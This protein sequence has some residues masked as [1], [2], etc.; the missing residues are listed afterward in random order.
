MKDY[1]WTLQHREVN[2]ANKIDPYKVTQGFYWYNDTEFENTTYAYSDKIKVSPNQVYQGSNGVNANVFRYVTF[3]DYNGVHLSDLDGWRDNF[4]VPSGAY[5]CVVTFYSLEQGYEDKNIGMTLGLAS[6]FEPYY[7]S[8]EVEAIYKQLSRGYKLES[9]KQF[10]REKMDGGVKLIRE[11]FDYINALPFD[12]EF[13]IL[14]EDLTGIQRDYRGLF[15]KTD[16]KWDDDDRIVELK[17]EPDDEYVNVLAGLDKT[18]NLINLAPE[19]QEITLRRRPLIQVYIPGDTVVTNILGGTHWE[20]EIQTDPIFDH[21]ALINTYKFANPKNIRIVP[22]SYAAQLSTD[23]TGEYDDNRLNANGLYRLEEVNNGVYWYGKYYQI[24]RVSDDVVLYKTA[25]TDWRNTSINSLFFSGFGGE[26]GGFYFT[27]YNIYVRYYTDL[28]DVRGTS[29]YAVP[30][31]DIVANNRNYRRVIGYNIDDFYIY[32][33][34]VEYPTKYGKVPNGAPDVGKYYK[35]F[36]VSVA[37]GLSNPLP[38][39]STNWKTVSLWFFNNL[40]IR[41]TEFIDGMDFE[42]RDSFALE[43]VIDVML[44]EMGSTVRHKDTTEYSE[45]LYS[46]TNPLGGFTYLDFGGGTI[47]TDYSGNIRH[48]LTPKSNIIAG[49]YDQ[50]AQKANASLGQILNMLRDC[51]R[52]FW[53]IDN[54]K[55]RLEHITWY[56]NGGTYIGVNIGAD[57]TTLK[58]PRNGKKWNFSQSK[59]EYDKE[60]MPERFEFGWMD[61]VSPPFEGKAIE[62]VGN[63]VQR[64]RIEDMAVNGIT[65]D[66]DFVMSNP[67]E[68]SKDGF[69]LLS[70]VDVDGVKRVPFIEMDIGYN[71]EVVMQNGF[72]SWLYLHPKFYVYDLPGDR[73]II[74]GEEVFLFQNKTR[75]KKQEV[76][77]PAQLQISPYNIIRTNL[78]DGIV[79]S[80]KIDMSSRI[81]KATIKHD[82]E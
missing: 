19:L 59:Y 37:T 54:G 16:C 75:H 64:G 17:F 58:Q 20:Q 28:L 73:A 38:V 22:A 57:L 33:Q 47:A 9:G 69:C 48:Y 66:I 4:T 39:S 24:V 34:F 36:L 77:F 23:I 53:H 1:R 27:E 56:Q 10:Y 60:E 13:K 82:T 7:K 68:V 79:D 62:M 42:L 31:E 46:A 12:T 63:Y 67:Q 72:L 35:E 5:S 44:R 55:L 40:D 80:L 78:G 14:V 15:Y 51:Y 74:N 29:T 61:D 71:Q 32:D 26:T 8:R 52:I 65:S 43:S 81:V 70:T 76:I 2:G 25:N 50:P 6:D 49:E 18:Y 3:Y 30:S 45:V 21:N 41:Y 11:D